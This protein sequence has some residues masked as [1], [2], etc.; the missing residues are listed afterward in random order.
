MLQTF[1]NSEWIEN[2]RL[3]RR[4]FEMLCNDLDIYLTA[5]DKCVRQPLGVK[6]ASGVYII[7]D[8]ID[9]KVSHNRELIWVWEI[10]LF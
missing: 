7:L 2:L 6:K 4:T 5:K 8:V 1:D 3:E 9:I 10:K